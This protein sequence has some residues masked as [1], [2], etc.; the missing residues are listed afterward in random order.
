MAK[1]KVGDK[2]RIVVGFY[3]TGYV[4]PCVRPSDHQIGM[5]GHVRSVDQDYP[6][7]YLP[8]YKVEF[9]E[10]GFER[11]DEVHL[12]LVPEV[13]VKLPEPQQ[14]VVDSALALHAFE[15]LE[16]IEAKLTAIEERLAAH[17]ARPNQSTG[18][19][20][21]VT[22]NVSMPAEMAAIAPEPS[23]EPEAVGSIA[24]DD[25][26][27]PIMN[28]WLDMHSKAFILDNFKVGDKVEFTQ[29]SGY[30]SDP[31]IGVIDY[32][33]VRDDDQFLAISYDHDLY[34]GSRWPDLSIRKVRKVIE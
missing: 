10:G 6:A 7:G 1:F 16:R 24:Y 23:A 22:G 8:D 11:I 5:V 31:F 14:Y 33:D 29:G 34:R 21:N 15:I 19:M 4:F 3:P 12:E 20:I 17:E 32:F 27:R 30:R 28:P 25:R 26:P 18:V 9:E 2:V 13:V